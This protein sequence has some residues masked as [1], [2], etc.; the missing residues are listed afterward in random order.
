VFK[1]HER[2]KQVVQNIERAVT[3]A[4]LAQAAVHALPAQPEGTADW[5]AA[6]GTCRWTNWSADTGALY[7]AAAAGCGVPPLWHLAC[8]SHI[9]AVRVRRRMQ[10]LV[11]DYLDRIKEV[12]MP[13]CS[14][15]WAKVS[16]SAAAIQRIDKLAER[17]RR[18]WTTV[19]WTGEKWFHSPPELGCVSVAPT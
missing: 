5:Q 3:A 11:A 9:D 7:Y 2:V 10:L 4:E 6:S 1:K 19:R 12:L 18:G 16:R 14:E 15:Q 13:T 8:Q 17:E